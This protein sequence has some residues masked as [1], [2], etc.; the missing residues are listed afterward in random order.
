MIQD[1]EPHVYRNEY[2]PIPPK[3]DSYVL[4]YKGANTLLHR[5]EEGIEFPRFRD[6]EPMN[7]KI[8][9]DYTYLF[10]IDQE[11]YYLIEQIPKEQIPSGF[12]MEHKEAFRELD[13]QYKAFAGI[14]GY[15]LYRWY[16]SNHFCGKCG[17]VMRK[18]EKERM[19]YCDKCRNMVYPKLS[20]AV[21]VGITDGNR[22]LMSQYAGREF[23]KYALIAGFAEIGESLE[24]TVR[25]E[26]MEEVGLHVKNIRYY[27]SQPWSFTDSLLMGFYC[28]LDGDDRITLE[29]DEL[30][31]AK[32][33]E[34][35]DIPTKPSRAS[36][37]NEMI[38]RF[39][40]GLE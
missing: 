14:T 16:R 15:Q 2:M 22:L 3:P 36:L 26:V 28:D 12:M 7:P 35:E 34:R 18:D 40:N 25:R 24:D 1:I 27:K 31:L 4:Y 9:E 37:T 20:P 11:P 17:A 6:L 23:K 38:M 13:P 8:Y 29:E 5:T 32:W 33:I 10:S 21:I 30:S 19:M 39:K